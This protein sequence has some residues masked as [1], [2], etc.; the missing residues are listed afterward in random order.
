MVKIVSYEIDKVQ[1]SAGVALINLDFNINEADLIS[2][3]S[4]GSL[5]IINAIMC[6]NKSIKVLIDTTK[7][8]DENLNI[9][10]RVCMSN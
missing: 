9:A 7:S 2:V 8:S 1:Y 4:S 3:E 6:S 5:H 10:L